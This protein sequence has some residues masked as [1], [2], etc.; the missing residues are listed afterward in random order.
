MASQNGLLL[1]SLPVTVNGAGGGVVLFS[2]SPFLL[3]P[4]LNLL[5]VLV[6][7]LGDSFPNPYFT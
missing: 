2:K 7:K 4:S 5:F 1:F 6:E 3:S